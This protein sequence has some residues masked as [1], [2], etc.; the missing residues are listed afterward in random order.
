MEIKNIHETEK[1]DNDVI[2]VYTGRTLIRMTD[3]GT[4]ENYPESI[5]M[6][7]RQAQEEYGDN[8]TQVKGTLHVS[9]PDRLKKEGIKMRLKP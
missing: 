4:P 1:G 5:I 9:H 6:V 3:R 7:R 8:L 2:K